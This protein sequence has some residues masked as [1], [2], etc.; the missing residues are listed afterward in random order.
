M[1]ATGVATADREAVLYRHYI[2]GDYVDPAG[3]AWLDSLDPYRNA[4]WARV[5]RGSA[6]DVGRAVAAA[7]RGPPG[8]GTACPPRRAA[9]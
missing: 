6:E 2:D 1:T 9:R 7:Q 5:P 3:G 8:P 4:V